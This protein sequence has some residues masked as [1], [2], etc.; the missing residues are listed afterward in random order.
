MH[1]SVL[2]VRITLD[3]HIPREIYAT[4]LAIKIIFISFDKRQKYPFLAN[5]IPSIFGSFAKA[6]L[7]IC[8]IA[9][10]V[11][12][13]SQG[14]HSKCHKALS[15]EA[16]TIAYWSLWEKKS[17]GVFIPSFCTNLNWREWSSFVFLLLP[18]WFLVFLSL[19]VIKLR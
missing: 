11:Q 3:T 17:F 15:I 16:Y 6:K 1:E 14:G 7:P 9:W 4:T 10:H 5:L 13:G 12:I 2:C 18:S 8:G 19:W